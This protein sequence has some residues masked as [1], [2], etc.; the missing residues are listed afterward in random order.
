[1]NGE[2]KEKMHQFLYSNWNL[3]MNSVEEALDEV[4]A[5]YGKESI[6]SELELMNAFFSSEETD[7]RKTKFIIENTDIYWPNMSESPLEWLN[8]VKTKFEEALQ[9][10]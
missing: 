9:T 3:S 1:M 4:I 5:D 10:K 8:R 6:M 2:L 7:E